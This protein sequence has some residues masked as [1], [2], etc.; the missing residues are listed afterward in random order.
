MDRGRYHEKGRSIVDMFCLFIGRICHLGREIDACSVSGLEIIP[1]MALTHLERT[2]SL[3]VRITC[4]LPYTPLTILSAQDIVRPLT[5]CRERYIG[6]RTRFVSV[7]LIAPGRLVVIILVGIEVVLTLTLVV[8]V[9]SEVRVRVI[10]V[11]SMCAES[12]SS[13]STSGSRRVRIISS[14]SFLIVST[15]AIVAGIKSTVLGHSRSAR[16]AKRSVSTGTVLVVLERSS[17]GSGIGSS[18]GSSNVPSTWF[19]G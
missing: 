5:S 13:S 2:P 17:H 14:M 15:R 9:G 12:S 18:S 7:P 1:S 10:R 16:A 3:I 4:M 19:D 8:L 6:I 11:I